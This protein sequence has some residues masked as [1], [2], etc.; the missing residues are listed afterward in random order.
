MQPL[1][2]AEKRQC[3]FIF[4]AAAR[5]EGQHTALKE[6]GGTAQP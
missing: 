3:S 1:V 6:K 4:V 5:I 2:Q